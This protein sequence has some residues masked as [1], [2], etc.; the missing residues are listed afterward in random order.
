MV[1]IPLDIASENYFSNVD[2]CCLKILY[3][4]KQNGT[5]TVFRFRKDPNVNKINSFTGRLCNIIFFL[6][7]FNATVLANVFAF[8]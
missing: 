5:N 1:L 4:I 6:L 8:Q 7:K 2:Y 3:L